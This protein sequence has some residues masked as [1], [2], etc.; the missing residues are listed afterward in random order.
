M[1]W[2]HDKKTIEKS[3]KGYSHF[4]ARTDMR[5]MSDYVVNP[6]NIISHAFYP[7]IHYEMKMDKYNKK[8]GK[9]PKKRDIYYASHR[10]RCVFQYYA[11]LIN[12]KYNK[13]AIQNGIDKV[14]VAYR[15]N[16]GENNIVSSKRAFD[17]M[18][19]LRNCYVMIGD[20]KSFF[21]N[22]DHVYL[23]AQINVLL[24]T[25]K[26]PED[27][28]KIF[29]HVTNYSYVELSSLLELNGLENTE[30]SRR[31]LNKKRTVIPKKI[32]N[33]KRGL[34]VKKN[35]FTYGIPQGSPISAVLANVYMVTADKNINEYITKYDGFYMRYSDDFIVIIPHNAEYKEIFAYVQNVIKGIPGLI[36]EN[37]KTQF[38]SLENGMITNIGDTSL[39][40]ADCS[41]KE[42]NFLGFTFDGKTIK[43]RAKT[44]GKYYYRLHRKAKVVKSHGGKK[45]LYEKYS[46][47]GS[48]QGHGN[49][50]T[51]VQNAEKIYGEAGDMRHDLANNM[52]KIKHILE[53]S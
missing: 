29:K 39:E 11:Y 43:L 4:D 19:S 51:Y 23:K 37:E 16:L 40:H 14:A 28:Y 21:D 52:G 25:E 48:Y 46:E 50:F 3:K 22:L 36:L 12:E 33:E 24:G 53:K 6:S 8:G 27:Y 34:L 26:L 47:R 44:V 10:D 30:S 45:Y 41:K 13:L 1:D 18:K 7:F 15:N 17:F 42:I 38:F 9:K 49:F 2:L 32:F 20:F 5:I 31:K 35:E